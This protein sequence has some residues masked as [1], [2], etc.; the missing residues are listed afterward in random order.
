MSTSHPARAASAGRR[1][2][3]GSRPARSAN[4]PFRLGRTARRLVLLV[5]LVAALGWFGVDVVLGVLAVTGF[6]S[7][8]PGRVAASYLALD[9]FAVPLLLIFGLSTL[10]SGLL[11]SI[12]SGWGIIRYW[13]LTIKLVLNLA[14]SGLVLILLQPRVV[15]AAEQ[16]GR[17]DQTLRDRIGPIALNL[18]FPAF[19]SGTALLVAAVLATFKPWGRTPYGRRREA[20]ASPPRAADA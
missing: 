5:H 18:L 12:G 2:A 16:A 15:E 3:D 10:G 19:V 8:D 4:R 7:D 20:G 9:T 11:L 13:W 14:L 6:T 17:V 1:A